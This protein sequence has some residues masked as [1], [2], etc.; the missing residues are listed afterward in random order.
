MADVKAYLLSVCGVALVCSIAN[1][2]LDNKGSAAGIGKLLVGSFLVLTVLKPISGLKVNFM[3]DLTLD[4][5]DN[6]TFAVHQ[7][8]E[9]Y[10]QAMEEIIKDRTEAYIV[11]KA[12]EL[13]VQLDVEVVLSEDEL[14]VPEKVFVSGT[15]APFAKKQLQQMIEQDLGIAKEC[16]I[17]T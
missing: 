5:G 12:Q 16:Q 9:N 13:R 11:Q 8:E 7:G 15:V 1:R 10:R 14:P 2:F 6:A 4:I 3:R 17:W